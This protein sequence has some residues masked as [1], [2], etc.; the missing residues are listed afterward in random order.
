MSA[1]ADQHPLA[2]RQVS[3]ASGR[4]SIASPRRLTVAPGR[5]RASTPP[6]P[7]IPS[8]CF[9]ARDRRWPPPDKSPPSLAAALRLIAEHSKPGRSRCAVW[10]IRCIAGPR[11]RARLPSLSNDISNSDHP[12]ASNPTERSKLFDSAQPIINMQGLATESHAARVNCA[13]SA[14]HTLLFQGCSKN[15]QLFD[16]LA[17]RNPEHEPLAWS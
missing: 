2:A 12:S 13:G 5:L 9:G 6:W 14:T 16:P 3:E 11:Q 10:P 4:C 1:S 17:T 8:R 7:S 15:A